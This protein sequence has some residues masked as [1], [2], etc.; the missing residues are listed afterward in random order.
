[1]G[2][3]G[4]TL[5]P[6][7]EVVDAVIHDPETTIVTI[8]KKGYGK[9]TKLNLYRLTHRGGKGVI[10][11]KLRS[12]ND[13]VIAVKAVPSEKNLLLASVKGLLIRIRTEDIRETGR[14]TMGV[15]VMRFSADDD[16][17]SSVALCDIEEELC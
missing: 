14:A 9:H 10:N 16:E 1:M 2:V 15:I 17:I 6:D 4:I 8:T 11:I 3:K 13:E 5:R 12:E 7:D